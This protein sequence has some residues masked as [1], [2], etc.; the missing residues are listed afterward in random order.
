MQNRTR[1]SGFESV[2]TVEDGGAETLSLPE[3]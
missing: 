1:R 2:A 3:R